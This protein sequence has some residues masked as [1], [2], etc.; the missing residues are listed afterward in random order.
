MENFKIKYKIQSFHDHLERERDGG[1]GWER[2]SFWMISYV[3]W[4]HKSDWMYGTN[5]CHISH[6]HA[7][8]VVKPKS[9]FFWDVA[10][11]HWV[12]VAHNSETTHPATQHT[13]QENEDLNN[14]CY[15]Y[16]Q[17]AIAQTK[18]IFKASHFYFVLM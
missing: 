5:M 6:Q 17:F 15:S 8:R 11:H 16:H 12:F 4:V 3:N 13:T 18:V 14:F 10:F 2:V 7:F 1:R 9:S